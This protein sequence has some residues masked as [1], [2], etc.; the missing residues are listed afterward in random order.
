MTTKTKPFDCIAAK[1]RSHERLMQEYEASKERF[2]SP[3]DFLKAKTSRL[4]IAQDI[5]AKIARAREAV[6]A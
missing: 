1:R 5:R 2:V 4:K 3:V 6:K